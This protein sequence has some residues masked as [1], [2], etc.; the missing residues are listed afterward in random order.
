[1]S[2]LLLFDHYENR[3]ME[4]KIKQFIKNDALEAVEADAETAGRLIAESLGWK[5]EGVP[6][7]YVPP[8]GAVFTSEWIKN[9][10]LIHEAEK[11]VIEK[12]GKYE[13]GEALISIFGMSGS[14]QSGIS[15][16]GICEIAT[17]SA[18]QRIAAMLSA[19]SE[20]E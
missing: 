15:L 14:H 11:A 18:H 5:K 20:V 8:R 6:F 13:Y 16:V 12:V 17:A 4:N 7:V 1:M 3:L 9:S 19:L 2:Y 10:N